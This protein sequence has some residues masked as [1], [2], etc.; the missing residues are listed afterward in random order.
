MF[1]RREAVSGSALPMDMESA[2]R[3]IQPDEKADHMKRILK[4]LLL[5]VISVAA[6]S[7]AADRITFYTDDNFTGR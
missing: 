5:G 1:S 6:G 4:P 2:A 7:A 3:I